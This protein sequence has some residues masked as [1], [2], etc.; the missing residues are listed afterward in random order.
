MIHLVF[1]FVF[2]GLDGATTIDNGDNICDN[3]DVILVIIYIYIIYYNICV[4]D[5]Y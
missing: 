4:C 3:G 1:S 5:R 2:G